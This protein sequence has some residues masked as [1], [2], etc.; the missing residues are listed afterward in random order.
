MTTDL[1]TTQRM[2]NDFSPS[3]FAVAVDRALPVFLAYGGIRIRKAKT[4]LAASTLG[5]VGSLSIR[6][7]T[8]A[9]EVRL[10]QK[11]RYRVFYEEMAV[12]PSPLTALARRDIHSYDSFCDHLLVC[13]DANTPRY[14][15]DWPAVVGTYRLLRQKIAQRHGGFYSEN[16]FDLNGVLAHQ[17]GLNF[18]ELGRSCVLP[19]Y[20]N[21]STLELLWRGIWKYLVHH[22]CDVLIGCASF[23]RTDVNKPA[24]PLS[25]LHHFAAAP[26]QWKATAPPGRYVEMNRIPKEQ[27]NA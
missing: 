7:A 13:D 4:T 19:E 15:S 20:R 18:L 22:R 27:I 14:N 24:L 3:P 25:F 2:V 23:A 10:A 17:C 21:K 11:L 1:T 26:Q 6:L 9:K 16:E 12:V 8:D 5:H